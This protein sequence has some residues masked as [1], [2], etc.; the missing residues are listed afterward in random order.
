MNHV[1]KQQHGY[2]MRDGFFPVDK[3]LPPNNHDICLDGREPT[4]SIDGSNTNSMP[5]VGIYA[6]LEQNEIAP[7]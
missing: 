6:F 2:Q 4:I 5:L 3:C 1:R 7:L